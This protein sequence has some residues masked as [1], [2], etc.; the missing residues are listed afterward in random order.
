MR[1]SSF[2]IARHVIP[3]LLVLILACGQIDSFYFFSKRF[4]LNRID[5][6]FNLYNEQEKFLKEQI[7]ILIEWHKA[8]E[9]PKITIFLSDF[10]K[11]FQNGLTQQD[12]DWTLHELHFLWK[13]LV[14]QTIPDYAEFLKTIDKKQIEHLKSELEKRNEHLIDLLKLNDKELTKDSQDRL[15][16]IVKNCL[17]SLLPA[18]EKQIRNR[19]HNNR[20]WFQN[21][22]QEAR[23]SNKVLLNLIKSNKSAN[24]IKKTLSQWAVDPESI[25]SEKF[26]K[27]AEERRFYWIKMT[28]FIDSLITFDQRRY[29][30]TKIQGYIDKIDSYKSPRSSK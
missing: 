29:A 26:A 9:L 21:R 24:E 16:K 3:A 7:K 17:G 22:V 30:L 6:Y 18:Q 12:I 10:K 5:N 19:V 1:K 14:R 2:L 20:I 4:L 25:W 27:K 8:Q 13:R 15:I 11:R 23:R 28:I